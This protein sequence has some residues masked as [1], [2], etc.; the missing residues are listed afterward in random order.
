M[1]HR[2]PT[3]SNTICFYH[4]AH[5]KLLGCTGLPSTDLKRVGYVHTG[6]T[7]KRPY[8]KVTSHICRDYEP[9]LEMNR[10]QHIL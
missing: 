1:E 10:A 7:D 5:Q 9:G 2:E 4:T 3:V 8:D 6:L